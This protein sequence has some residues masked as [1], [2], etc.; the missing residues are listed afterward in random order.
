MTEPGVPVDDAT[1]QR[2]AELALRIRSDQWLISQVSKP[3]EGTSFWNV[4]HLYEVE[5]ISQWCREGIRSA[6]DH[7]GHW[8]DVAIP[9][10]QFEG[11][12][13]KTNGFRWYF[14][15]MRA[16]MEGA[17]Q[18]IWLSDSKSAPEALAR[19]VRMVRHDL[20][21]QFKAWDAMGRDTTRISERVAKHEEA[22]S[23]LVDHGKDTPRLPAMV[24][25]VRYAAQVLKKDPDIYEGHWRVCSAAAHGKD[26][27]IL[28]LQ[29]FVG[30][31]VEWMPGQF[32]SK[33]YPDPE[34]L[35]RMLSDTTDLM[36]GAVILYLQRAYA[37]PTGEL[38]QRGA[39][40]AAKLTPQKDGGALVEAIGRE[41]GL[42]AAE[43][44]ATVESP[45]EP[46]PGPDPDSQS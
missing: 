16:A 1:R 36:G 31:P 39:F 4:D 8:A 38:L 27:A 30:D 45:P 37:G 2:W 20:G 10:E 29:K 14:T 26:W 46:P 7:L 18:S 6:V 13:V 44:D 40:E 3:D 23:A 25:L 34:L 24:D 33:G 28:E 11:Q 9:L 41:W 5:A 21:E 17:A 22:A 43:D 42:V 12:V 15:L 19:L 35:T 32:H